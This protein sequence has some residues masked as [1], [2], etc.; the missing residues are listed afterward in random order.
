MGNIKLDPDKIPYN[1]EGHTIADIA[2]YTGCSLYTV[3]AWV[4]GYTTNAKNWDYDIE[5]IRGESKYHSK[6]LRIMADRF[7]IK[8]RVRPNT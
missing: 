2:V 3:Q 6:G 5:R 8:K 4:L 1:A 7:I